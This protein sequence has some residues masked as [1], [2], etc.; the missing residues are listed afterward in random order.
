[1]M[2][3]GLVR[4]KLSVLLPFVA[5]ALSILP[6]CVPPAGGPRAS[7]ESAGPGTGALSADMMAGRTEVP[8][9][10]LAHERELSAALQ[11][12]VEERTR[13]VQR[14]RTEIKQLRRD[15]TDLRAAL[16][17]AL[18]TVNA[19]SPGSAP[20]GISAGNAAAQASADNEEARTA[21]AAAEQTRRDLEQQHAATTA[22]LQSALAQ[23][24][25]RREQ[26]ETELSRLKQETSSPPYGDGHG[27]EAELT[28]AKREVVELRTALDQE[29]AV[30]ERL[31]QD[32]RA[33]Q[34]RADAESAGTQSA[35]AENTELRLQLKQLEEEKQKITESFNRS[36]AESQQRATE[37]EGQLAQAHTVDNANTTSAGDLTNIR[38]ENSALRTRLDEEHRRT[39]ELAA[40]L[41]IAARVTDL[42]FKM[43]GQRSGAPVSR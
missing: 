21:A 14:L 38:A 6:A 43:Q 40:K 10:A 3:G 5:V 4:S 22:R 15:Q 25:Q 2:R 12:L 31:A 27:S 9:Q 35:N 37:L 13:D 26:I 39:E 23:E 30:R 11:Q 34:Q 20:S 24:Q 28:S 41:K 16:D 1:M 29:R 36:L 33:L 18:A 42:I 32:F 17:R 8:E 19:G 7:T